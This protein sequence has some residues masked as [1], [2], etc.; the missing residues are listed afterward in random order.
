MKRLYLSD[1]VAGEIGSYIAEQ[2]LSAGD[3]LPSV[4]EWMQRLRVGRST[5]RE[6]LKRL[7]AEGVIQV[8][9]GKGIYV[10]DQ[11]TFRLFSR[12]HVTDARRHLLEM[13]DVRLVLE[14]KAIALATRHAS[15]AQLDEMEQFLSDYQVARA[16]DDFL[17]VHEADSAFHLAIYRASHNQV[18]VELIRSI[19][20][21]L[22]VS[23]QTPQDRNQVFDA[24][25]PHH[26]T[27]LA[28]M[29]RRDVEAA[30]AAFG[31]LMAA[32]RHNV[33]IMR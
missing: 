12:L 25:F 13:L 24:S 30:V 29:R 6:G 33:E 22:Y 4:A 18:L 2:R 23:W 28:A 19:H 26:L 14:E 7:E 9:N 20:S 27:L 32:T 1:T 5:L 3:R 17:R 15:E 11:Q 8:V 16:A 31:E 21:E 10:S